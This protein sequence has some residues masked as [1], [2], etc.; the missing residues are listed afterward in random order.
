MSQNEG[1]FKY[2]SIGLKGMIYKALDLFLLL[3]LQ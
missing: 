3:G 1:F 2:M